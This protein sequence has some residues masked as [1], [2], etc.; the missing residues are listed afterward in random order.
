MASRRITSLNTLRAAISSGGKR[1][2]NLSDRFGS[3]D[4]RCERSVFR[5]FTVNFGHVVR[6]QG[7]P[8]WGNSMV[9]DFDVGFTASTLNQRIVTVDQLPSVEVAGL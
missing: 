7:R 3:A 2:R 6:A 8:V 1:T 9:G 4:H 5:F